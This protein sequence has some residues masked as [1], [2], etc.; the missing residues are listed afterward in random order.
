VQPLLKDSI[1]LYAE[2]VMRLN[3]GAT[4]PATNDAALDGFGKRLT[5]WGIPSGAQQLIDGSGLSR[6]DT[7]SPEAMLGV[8]QHMY[9]PSASSP[10]ITGLP[11][12]GVD[13]SLSDRMRNTTAAG[14]VRAKTG[15]MSNIRT[16]GGYATTRD[17][18]ALAFVAMVNN[19][20]GSGAA[21][22]QALDAIAVALASF[23]RTQAAS[24]GSS[25]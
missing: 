7:V 23:S 11:I 16:L 12:A 13:G 25:K 14:N 17:G 18:E 8:L 24:V 22:N 5:A 2:A 19:F 21:A 20:E 4:R 1:N 10:F 6:R 3:A 15:T 9:E